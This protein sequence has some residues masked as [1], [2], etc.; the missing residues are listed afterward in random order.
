M[1]SPQPHGLVIE[2][3]GKLTA[4]DSVY[5]DAVV[6][7]FLN[8]KQVSNL[9]NLRRYYDLP[10]GGHFIVQHMGGIFRVIIYKGPTEKDKQESNLEK[11]GVPML[12]CGSISTDKIANGNQVPI[13]ISS[14]TRKRLV[15]YSED[16]ELPKEQLSLKRFNVKVN[17]NVVP[18]FSE[19]STQYEL[20]R[21]TWY[22]G[23]MAE[24]MQI[25]GGYGKQP[26]KVDFKDKTFENIQMRIPNS[27]LSS[28][29][30][31]LSGMLLP[32]YTGKP[33]TKGQFQYDYKFSKTHAIGFD[34]DQSPW[35]LQ[36]SKDGLF[37]MP[38]PVIPATTTKAFKLYIL[39]KGDTELSMII[40]KFGG[41]PSGESFPSDKEEFKAWQRAGVIIKLCDMA[42]FYKNNP[43][44]D[45]CG[46]SFNTK[47]DTGFN[48]CQNVKDGYNISLS[49]IL[50]ITLKA[51]KYK[52]GW[53]SKVNV[54]PENAEAVATYIASIN[55]L[56]D[57]KVKS[58]AIKYKM[59]M[60]MDK[61]IERA[62]SGDTGSDEIDY[63]DKLEIEPIANHNGQLLFV[64]SGKFCYA[65]ENNA[66]PVSS[67]YIKVLD[68][69]VYKP[70]LGVYSSPPY[71]M[72]LSEVTRNISQN[73]ED[74]PK[75]YIPNVTS[76]M[77]SHT[78]ISP[79]NVNW[80]YNKNLVCNTVMYGYFV[81]DDFKVVRYYFDSNINRDYK[82]NYKDYNDNDYAKMIGSSSTIK[83]N[84]GVS[85]IAGFYT[86]DFDMKGYS[87]LLD[88]TWSFNS[89]T[90][91]LSPGFHGS[92]YDK[93]YKAIGY[94]WEQNFSVT[95]NKTPNLCVVIPCFNRNESFFIK[96]EY[97][98]SKYSTIN[99]K[100]GLSI[101]RYCYYFGYDYIDPK[102]PNLGVNIKVTTEMDIA[103]NPSST[104]YNPSI[105]G[106]YE[107][108]PQWLSVGQ[109]V[110][111]GANYDKEYFAIENEK[112]R[113]WGAGIKNSYTELKLTSSVQSKLSSVKIHGTPLNRVTEIAD[114][115]SRDSYNSQYNQPY[116]ES[117][118]VVFGK[119][120][121][122]NIGLSKDL[123]DRKTFGSTKFSDKTMLNFIGV[124]NE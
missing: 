117:C 73:P 16:A 38:L 84:V 83:L 17:D 66:D 45:A 122:E 13:K 71:K 5:V 76:S 11:L 23:A 91:G 87:L 6:R 104:I 43:Y 111:T 55:K 36:V 82:N 94:A 34:G 40:D 20:Q 114:V 1:Y 100:S 32:G 121:Y 22:S 18:E 123:N 52:N 64:N 77:V 106:T 46:W 29:N 80:K 51:S 116:L 9:E 97:T 67:E 19:A 79:Q 96:K 57:D 27:V 41:L 53:V 54:P 7:R 65:V 120:Q 105:I 30:S 98:P 112:I 3:G 113:A 72:V 68:S 103:T 44:S 4:Q 15:Q 49:Y 2:G 118:K 86:T 124:I 109:I 69:T 81:G 60:T 10:N 99:G 63:W 39:D 107:D 24:V 28:I 92:L 62:S 47:A 102:N 35:L 119:Q 8:F 110:Y 74:T 50:L 21:P 31:E 14:L 61:V 108:T 37:A 101:S 70:S 88:A 58:I 78:A 26:K 75:L 90:T 48:T 59:R 95:L 56:L 33:N 42:E 89:S 25:I 115:T 12:F 93:A 85:N